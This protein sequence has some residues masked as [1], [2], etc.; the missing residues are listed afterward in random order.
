MNQ[1]VTTMSDH[2]YRSAADFYWRDKVESPCST[3]AA[4]T[5]TMVLVGASAATAAT[6]PLLASLQAFCS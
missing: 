6:G 1:S 2:D 3:L 5:I 4:L